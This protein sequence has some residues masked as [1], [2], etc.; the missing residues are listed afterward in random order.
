VP[1][2]LPQL[3]QD[4]IR[5]LI[6]RQQRIAVALRR[7]RVIARM[8]GVNELPQGV[9]GGIEGH[10]VHHEEVP[11]VVLHQAQRVA[12]PPLHQ[13]QQVGDEGFLII[14]LGILHIR[15]DAIGA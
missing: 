2:L 12:G 8:G 11:L 4:G 13:R 10:E 7:L 14:A 3:A 15:A 5:F 9:L 6:K 1:Y